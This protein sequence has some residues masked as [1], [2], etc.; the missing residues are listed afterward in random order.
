MILCQPVSSDDSLMGV[1]L[2]S[3]YRSRLMNNTLSADSGSC[4][5]AVTGGCRL[6]PNATSCK[7]R[8]V[9]P[10]FQRPSIST[11]ASL[12]FTSLHTSTSVHVISSNR[13]TSHSR[14]QAA[15]DPCYPL[16][17]HSACRP[18]TITVRSLLTSPSHLPHPF[19]TPPLPH[20]T[21]MRIA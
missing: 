16:R 12:L 5:A 10:N 9:C 1:A 21:T 8:T 4:G 20:P 11:I 7:V 18:L 3:S 13:P 19:L 17:P 14:G 2:P 6:D 15:I